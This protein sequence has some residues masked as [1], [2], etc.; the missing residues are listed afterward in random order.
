MNEFHSKNFT[1]SEFL[2]SGTA[3]RLHIDN[4]SK[5]TPEIKTSIANLVT[6][7]LQPARDIV[8]FPMTITSGFRC[9]A[10]NKAVGGSKTSQ[11][12]KGEAAD[13]QCFTKGKLDIPKMRK[14][15]EVLS[16]LDVDQLLY[17]RDSKGTIWIHVSYV[18]PKKNRHMIRDNYLTK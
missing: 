18:S 12:P 3:D 9:E 16:E 7:V 6:N 14:L 5:A 4:A 2:R 10:L 13:I 17:E 1:L 8:G 15:F 11:H